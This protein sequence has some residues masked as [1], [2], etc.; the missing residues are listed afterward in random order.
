LPINEPKEWLARVPESIT[1]EIGRHYAACIMHLDDGVGRILKALDE[2]GVRENTIFVFTS[3]NGGSTTTNNTQPYPPD[4]SPSGKLTANNAPLRGQKGTV[5]E[6]GTRAT[7]LISWPGKIAA[8]KDSTPTYIA[9]WMPTFCHLAGY[10]STQD[11]KWDGTDLSA[12]LLERKSIPDRPIYVAGP[13]WR[14]KSLRIGEWKLVVSG[15][16]DK[17][18]LE[19]F[20]ISKD[21][22]EEMNLA[23][24]EPERVSAM[25]AALKIQSRNDNDSK[26]K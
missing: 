5:Y 1:S 23:E 11:L 25:L 2:K 19:L 14:A 26:V 10:E 9:D 13:N 7:T 8:A 18:S 16:G 22:S 3:D 4:D 21:Q 15:E 6:G 20:Q 12:L 24:S 17:Q